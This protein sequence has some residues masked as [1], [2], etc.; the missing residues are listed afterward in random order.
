MGVAPASQLPILVLLQ[1]MVV[2]PLIGPVRL[3]IMDQ[4]IIITLQLLPMVS[5][6]QRARWQIIIAIPRR[7]IVAKVTATPL[8]TNARAIPSAA[9]TPMA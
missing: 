1:Q 6:I 4:I 8:L 2:T 5:H 9:P 3:I 7:A